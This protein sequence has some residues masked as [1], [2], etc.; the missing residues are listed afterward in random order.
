MAR[1]NSRKFNRILPS[2]VAEAPAQPPVTRA[3]VP[4]AKGV[5]RRQIMTVQPTGKIIW[6]DWSEHEKARTNLAIQKAVATENLWK[7]K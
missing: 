5:K 6:H 1:H 2:Q 4:E 3:A 7:R